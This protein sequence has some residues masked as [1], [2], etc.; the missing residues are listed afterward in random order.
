ML[1][2]YIEQVNNI[3]DATKPFIIRQLKRM[4]DHYYFAVYILCSVFYFL[5]I[6]PNKFGLLDKLIY[7]LSIIKSFEHQ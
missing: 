5:R 3:D 1:K 7:S 4:P 2:N 6:Q